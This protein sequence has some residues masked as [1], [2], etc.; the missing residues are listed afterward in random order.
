MNDPELTALACL[1]GMSPHRLRHLLRHHSPAD[2]WERLRVGAPLSAMSERHISSDGVTALQSQAAIATVQHAVD[3]CREAGI[4]VVDG[5]DRGW[6]SVFETDPDAPAA[7][8]IRG[9]LTSLSARR[10]GIVGTR[11]ATAA[12][13]A[14]AHELGRDLAS[15]GITVVSGLAR[16][17]DGAAHNG[18]RSVGNSR[19]SDTAE[20]VGRAAA[21]VGSGLDV[22]YPLRHRD[23]WEWVGQ[24][25][26]LISEHAPGVTPEPWHF[27]LR[28][29]IIAA[30]SEV[31]VVVESRESG[32]SL[33][34]ARL[35]LDLGVEVMVV[36]GS[37]HS[38]A[39]A[40]TNQLMFDGA[41]IARSADDVIGFL[42]LDHSRQQSVASEVRPAPTGA[43]VAVLEA[44]EERPS[45]L[46]MIVAATGC[47]V[48][49]VALA[50]ARLEQAG[51][52]LEAG[53]WFEP[54]TS[55]LRWS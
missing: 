6:P 11:N 28:N 49:D 25:G 39:S 47:S 20:G 33:I 32:G 8:F 14:S 24:T 52:L 35:A 19:P 54:A 45:T 10:V 15:A 4:S 18:V 29:R 42:G 50:A 9:D 23:L 40:G 41:G 51:W 17:I 36:P 2:A 34:T 27:P 46:D 16:G 26:V 12:G 3:R 38:R 1:P 44:C 30:L 22:P 21:V 13:R 31:L 37:T 48:L 7:L 43:Q 5:R 55:R 53:G